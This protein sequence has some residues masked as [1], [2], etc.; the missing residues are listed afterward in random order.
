M[1]FFAPIISILSNLFTKNSLWL[2]IDQCV[3]FLRTRMHSSRMRTGCSLTVCQ[4]LLLGGGL[5]LIPLNF[6]LGCGP[7][8]DPPQSPPWVGAWIWSPSISPLGC[9][10]RC[11]PPQF[12]PWVWAWTWSPS[13]SP[14]GV[15]LEGGFLGRGVSLAGVC[16]LPGGG[17]SFLGGGSIPACTEAD[18][19]VD[20]IT[21]TSKNI[22]LA[23]T[24]LRPVTK[25]SNYNDYCLQWKNKGERS[26]AL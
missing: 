10:P 23:T 9:G 8:S 11:D 6:S 15:G 25:S 12:P 26:C 18:P 22:T 3:K 17:A 14:L 2:W 4:S 5:D 24:S 20:R 7:G 21:D 13:I 1:V 16:F 19:P